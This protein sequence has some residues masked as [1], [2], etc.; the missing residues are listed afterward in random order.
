MLFSLVSHRNDWMYNFW[1]GGSD[2]SAQ[3]PFK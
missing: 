2:A 1:V 3:L